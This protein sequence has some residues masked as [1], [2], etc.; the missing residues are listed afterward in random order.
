MKFIRNMKVDCKK[1]FTGYGFYV[2]VFFTVALCLSSP[3]FADDLK[4]E[5]YSVV[6]VLRRFDQRLML[7]HA[8]MNRLI[9]SMKGNGGWLSLFIPIIAGFSFVPMLCDEY[10]AGAVRSAVFRSSIFCYHTDKFVISCISG[11]VAVMLGYGI[12]IC[13]V[14]VMFPGTDLYSGELHS[15]ICEEM[16]GMF[17]LP[18]ALGEKGTIFLKLGE[19]FLYGL[20]SV[21]PAT[22]LSSLTRNKYLVLCIPFFIQYGIT[23]ICTKM[24]FAALGDAEQ[25]Q[26]WLVRLVNVVQPDSIADLAQYASDVKFIALYHLLWMLVLY[27]GYMLIVRRRVDYGA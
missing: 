4:N 13:I 12:Y 27:A 21:L 9:V 1:I 10:H 11:G 2:S 24:R 25:I 19:V 15:L 7:E 22:F 6:D 5:T 23:Q 20:I 17:P 8:E 3:I 26:E 18:F 16:S 14:Y